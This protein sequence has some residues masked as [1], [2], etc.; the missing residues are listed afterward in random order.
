MIFRQGAALIIEMRG[1]FRKMFL[2]EAVNGSWLR[3]DIDD[4]TGD[5]RTAMVSPDGFDAM[6]DRCVALAGLIRD[7]DRSDMGC[8]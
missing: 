4:G 1:E 2:H 5:D 6:P 8:F 3:V 7:G